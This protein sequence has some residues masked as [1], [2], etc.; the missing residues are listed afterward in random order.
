MSSFGPEIEDDPELQARSHFFPYALGGQDA[1]QANP[2]YYTLQTL[3]QQNGH[4]FIDVLKVD[5]EGGEF[6]ALTSFI[7]H[8][9]PPRGP[10]NAVLPIGQLELEIHL[11]GQYTPF[12]V[13]KAW[14]ENLER[15]GLRPFWTEPNLVYV[16]KIQDALPDLAEVRAVKTFGFC[17]C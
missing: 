1:P 7:N 17:A 14:W 15:A 3:M 10:S 12:P 11:W 13:F 5:I 16:V 9:V 4:T 6:E 2:P 8:F